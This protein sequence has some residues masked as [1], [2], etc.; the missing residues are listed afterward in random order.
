MS[1]S[2]LLKLASLFHKKYS[3]ASSIKLQNKPFGY[4][5]EEESSFK[6]KLFKYKVLYRKDGE[7]REFVTFSKNE[8]GAKETFYDLKIGDELISITPM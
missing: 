6:E 1:V 5:F 8:D 3:Y 4:G 2:K 7:P